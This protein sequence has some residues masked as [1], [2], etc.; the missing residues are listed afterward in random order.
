MQALSTA[1]FL[2]AAADMRSTSARSS[3]R[4]LQSAPAVK[5][6][7]QGMVNVSI[8][9]MPDPPFQVPAGPR[10]AGETLAFTG[11]SVDLL[12]EVARLAGFTYVW[13]PRTTARQ[14][15]GWKQQTQMWS[16]FLFFDRILV[17]LAVVTLYVYRQT[18]ATNHSAKVREHVR[19]LYDRFD[20]DGDGI[21]PDEVE[22]I[23]AETDP[24]PYYENRLRQE[25]NEEE[26]EEEDEEGGNVGAVDKSFELIKKLPSFSLTAK[27]AAVAMLASMCM[28]VAEGV[29]V[30][31][32]DM[33][34]RELGPVRQ[35]KAAEA[36]AVVTLS[37]LAFENDSVLS[38][39]T[40]MRARTTNKIDFAT[41][42]V[43]RQLQ[44]D[45]ECASG[46]FSETNATNATVCTA[47]EDID[48]DEA[49]QFVA[50]QFATLLSTQH[51]GIESIDATHS[52]YTKIGGGIGGGGLVADF[53]NDGHMDTFTPYGS[54]GGLYF[55]DGTGQLNRVA[56]DSSNLHDVFTAAA[57]SA[58]AVRAQCASTLN[59]GGQ[60]PYDWGFNILGEDMNADGNMDIVVNFPSGTRLFLGDGSGNV[61][62][63]TALLAGRWPAAPEYLLAGDWNSDG[64]PDLFIS[65]PV[66]PASNPRLTPGMLLLSDGAGGMVEATSSALAGP[67][68]FVLMS[69][70][71]ADLDGDGDL[72]IWFTGAY[73]SQSQLYV[74]DGTGVF[75]RSWGLTSTVRSSMGAG[76]TTQHSIAADFDADGQI[77]LYVVGRMSADNQLL[78]G[79]AGGNFEADTSSPASTSGGGNAGNWGAPPVHALSIDGEATV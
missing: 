56:S 53:N 52:H 43:P 14:S 25:K 11:Y 62:E 13:V 16:P 34:G 38:G 63:D 21:K 5:N 6:K 64:A 30:S 55:N 29:T 50:C 32:L 66:V 69:V 1:A 10:H 79:T 28:P 51:E 42:G 4:M 65:G 24:Y 72:D 17:L 35:K 73:T 74:N 23:L 70:L 68:S 37:S 39:N 3:N 59:Y 20:V 45:V 67:H 57:D 7:M 76:T 71:T 27:L 36:P 58:E 60:C 22:L 41:T 44:D 2:D 31:A 48:E 54:D 18:M 78:W 61:A 26:G 77:D 49:L 8:V 40:S 33:S 75:S 46:Q 12:N 15:E 19:E 47:C 9:T